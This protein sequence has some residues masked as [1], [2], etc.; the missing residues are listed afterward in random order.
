MGGSTY[1]FDIWPGH[2]LEAEVKG[3]LADMRR[4]ASDLR[5]RVDAHNQS[6]G[7]RDGQRVTTYVGQCWVERETELPSGKEADA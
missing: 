2:P 4:R 1:A 7:L 6:R 3:Q 5:Q